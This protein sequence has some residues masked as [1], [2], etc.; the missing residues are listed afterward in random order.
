MATRKNLNL[1]KSQNA[2]TEID[3]V[4]KLCARGHLHC[5]SSRRMPIVLGTFTYC[6]AKII[7]L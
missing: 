1:F 3:L 5:N 2:V 6:T 4:W 7:D